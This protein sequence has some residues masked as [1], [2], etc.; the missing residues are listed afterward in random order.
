MFLSRAETLKTEILSSHSRLAPSNKGSLRVSHASSCGSLRIHNAD[1]WQDLTDTVRLSRETLACIH[2]KDCSW[3][4]RSG[5]SKPVGISACRDWVSSVVNEK[6]KKKSLR[7]LNIFQDVSTWSILLLTFSK[8]VE[9][10]GLLEKVVL[11]LLG[12]LELLCVQPFLSS[13]GSIV[14]QFKFHLAKVTHVI[15]SC[16]STPLHPNSLREVEK[17]VVPAGVP[18]TNQSFTVS[19]LKEMSCTCIGWGEFNS[20]NQYGQEQAKTRPH[21]YI[22]GKRKKITSQLFKNT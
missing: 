15:G 1:L 19:Q 5:R 10:L 8:I 22:Q 3:C 4:R 7:T 2:A 13:F 11:V 9:L 12:I 18:D 21:V 6:T 14:S 16:P 20:T 17:A